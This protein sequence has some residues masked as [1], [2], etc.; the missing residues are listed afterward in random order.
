M[1]LRGLVRSALRDTPKKPHIHFP[2]VETFARSSIAGEANALMEG[3]TRQTKARAC[4]FVDD[5]AKE[6]KSKSN[7]DNDE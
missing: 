3:D 2:W 5:I 7:S 4:I 6:G 1:K